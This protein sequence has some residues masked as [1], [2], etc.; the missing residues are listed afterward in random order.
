MQNTDRC[1][2]HKIFVRIFGILALFRRNFKFRPLHDL[3][4]F[5]DPLLDAIGIDAE[6]TCLGSM[7]YGAEVPA[8]SASEG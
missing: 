8:V 1:Q 6:I 4:P 2:A 7:S 5:L 3:I